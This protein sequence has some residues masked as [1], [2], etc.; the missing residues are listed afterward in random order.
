[1]R[2]GLVLI[3]TVLAVLGG[4]LV[5][6]LFFLSG[7]PASTT[8]TT[9]TDPGLPAHHNQSWALP[10]PPNSGSVSVSWTTTS[11]AN[12][13][14]SSATSCVSPSGFCPTGPP[15][16]NWTAVVSGKGTIDPA[17][18]S[19]Y[20]LTVSNPGSSPLRF[21]A[22]VSISYNT[23][24]PISAW[25]WGLIATGGIALLT[26]GGIALFL[27]LFLPGGVYRDPDAA[28]TARRHPSLP[29]DEPEFDELDHE[30]P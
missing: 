27:G 23:G 25:I 17:D 12:V 24:T 19:D 8:Q 2:T 20:L 9:F 16:L 18:A 28:L 4:G 5:L 11:A 15:S 14:V 1:V 3:G 6:S 21:T 10:G 22:V 7:G 29:P 26:I 13:S 30:P